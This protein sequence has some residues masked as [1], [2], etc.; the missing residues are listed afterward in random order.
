MNRLTVRMDHIGFSDADDY[1]SIAI[2]NPEDPEGW[3]NFMDLAERY[4]DC[5][6]KC[7]RKLADYEDMEERGLVQRK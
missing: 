6:W 7:I 1:D 2:K 5:L 4:P 3:H